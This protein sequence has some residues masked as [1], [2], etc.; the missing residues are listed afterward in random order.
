MCHAG[1]ALHC[2][3]SMVGV[4]NKT[5]R[6][7]VCVC[8]CVLCRCVSLPECSE[9]CECADLLERRFSSFLR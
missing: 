7:D 6:A 4:K 5:Q 3:N 2:L 9:G 1:H 8:V